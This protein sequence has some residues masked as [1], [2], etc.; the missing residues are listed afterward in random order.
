MRRY[1]FTENDREILQ[2]WLDTG[3]EDQQTR[4]LFSQIRKNVSKIRRDLTMMLQVIK[5]LQRQDRWH[6]RASRSDELGR[7]ILRTES[8]L[9]Q[10]KPR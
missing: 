8:K 7:A 4:N 5:K 9:R 6:G 2:K 3:H 1:I 10:A